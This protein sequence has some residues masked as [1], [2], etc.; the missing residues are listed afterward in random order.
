LVVLVNLEH[1]ELEHGDHES[2]KKRDLWIELYLTHGW[3]FADMSTFQN[4]RG[5][6]VRYQSQQG[7]RNDEGVSSPAN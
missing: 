2:E 4:E 5:I 1:V 3:C 6:S 7:D